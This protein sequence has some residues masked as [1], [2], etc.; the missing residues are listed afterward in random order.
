MSGGAKI[1][2]KIPKFRLKSWQYAV[3]TV[4]IHH[5]SIKNVFDHMVL[6]ILNIS[7]VE[8]Y[9]KLSSEIC[10]DKNCFEKRCE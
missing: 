8:I 5:Y 6:M 10:Y 3:G 4:V 1:G 2:S 7:P 9:L